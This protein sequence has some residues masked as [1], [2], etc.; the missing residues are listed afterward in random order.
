MTMRLD[1]ITLV[2][3]GDV[4]LADFASAIA[5]FYELVRALS[6]E[7]GNAELPWII[8]DLERSSALAAVK[9][10]EEP[11]RVERVVRA[12]AEVGSA[13]ERNAP[14]PYSPPVKSAAHALT[15]IVGGRIDSIRFETAEREATIRVAVADHLAP[16]EVVTVKSS[17]GS[18]RSSPA[19][20]GAIE[21]R[22]Q[23]L[24]NRGGLR[25]TL[26][27]IL[28]DKAVSCYLKE[29]YETIMRDAWGK[30]AIVEGWISRDLV[31]G[32]PLTIRQV[33]TVMVKSEGAGSSYRDARGVSPALSD[34]LP[35]QA[36]RRLR[37]A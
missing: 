37:D 2:L 8:D 18:I 19:A 34:L 28:N 16:S 13:L 11:E 20:Y 35:E 30:V 6:A 7:A 15:S 12:Y 23:T 31:T 1:T 17:P 29:G 22:I 32:R 9:C 10:I 4:Q 21:G 27:D 3:S 36:I 25:F 5:K 24:S 14:I 33:T 26:Y